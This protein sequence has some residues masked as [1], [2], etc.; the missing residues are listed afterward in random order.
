MESQGRDVKMDEK[1][2]EGYRNFATKLWNAARF[3]QSNGVTASTTHE[4]PHAEAPVNRW[5]IAET[6]ATVQAIDTAMAE[7]RFDAAA[8]AIYHF[9][10]DQFCDWYIELTKGSMDEETRAVAGWAFD[11]ILVML[12]PF[13]PFITEELWNLTGERESEL[14]VARWPQALYA[15][16]AQA[17]AEIDWLIRL[18]SAMRTART[19]LNVP[20]G[21]K[22]RVIARDASEETRR[23][24]DRQGA[25]LARLGRVESLSFGDAVEGGAAQVVVDEATFIL[26]LEGVI[27][28]GAEQARLAK[29][30]AS[31][32]K[33]RDSLSGRLSNPSFVEK[34]KPEAVAKAREDHAEKAAEAERLKAALDRLA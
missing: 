11:Q 24:I 14:I 16:D 13:M 20:P 2:V 9:V 17:Q 34:A 4:A 32:E 23:R 1:R 25:A 10:W 28:I 21:A 5:I 18:I 15:V 3:L 27:D 33:E 6:V 19:E 7:L 26:P 31:A 12:H 29:A 8:N 22:L 30:L